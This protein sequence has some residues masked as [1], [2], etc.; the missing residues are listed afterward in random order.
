MKDINTIRFQG[1]EHFAHQLVKF[2]ICH[3]LF[4]LKHHFKTEQFIGNGIC[5]VIDLDT[6]V[7]YEIESHVHP[8]VRRKKLET[9]YHPLISDIMIVDI[10]KLKHLASVL[11]F[12]DEI[13]KYCG[14]R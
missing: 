14:L 3:H 10:K 13:G 12:R 1:G 4:K 8:I 7:I 11:P 6:F 9:F 2:M 5:D